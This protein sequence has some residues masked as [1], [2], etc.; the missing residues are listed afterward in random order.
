MSTGGSDPS[1]LEEESGD[2]WK[3][4]KAPASGSK[5]PPSPN[6]RVMRLMR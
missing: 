4:M 2:V 3:P 5:V 1:S 6:D